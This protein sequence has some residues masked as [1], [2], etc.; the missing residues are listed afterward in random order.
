MRETSRDTFVVQLRRTGC[1]DAVWE[2]LT[3]LDAHTAAIPLTVVTPVGTHM[4]EGL[5]FIG[6]TKLGP[7]EISD[8]MLVLQADPPAGGTAG[9]LA[10]AKFGPMA[11]EVEATVDQRGSDVVIV[12]RQSFRPVWLPRFLRPVGAV[13]AHA[14]YGIGLRKLI[15]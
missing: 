12:W 15:K 11:G 10:V 8:R 5:E 2:K 6:L 4:S 9:R 1:A 13:I 3:D 14:A 7:V